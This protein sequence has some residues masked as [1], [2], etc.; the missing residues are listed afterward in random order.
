MGWATGSI[1]QRDAV[2]ARSPGHG[3]LADPPGAADGVF[4]LVVEDPCVTERAIAKPRG[5][6]GGCGIAMSVPFPM[7]G[8]VA[9]FAAR[10]I[11]IRLSCALAAVSALLAADPF[12]AI[13]DDEEQFRGSVRVAVDRGVSFLDKRQAANGEIGTYAWYQRDQVARTWSLWRRWYVGTPFT[14]SQVLHSLTFVEGGEVARR[15]RQ[16]AVAY[17][18]DQRE[19]PGVWRYY[20]KDRTPHPISPDVDDTAQAW[21][22]LAEQGIAVDRDALEALKRSRTTAGLFNTWIGNPEKWVGVDSRDMSVGVNLNAL[23]LFALVGQPVPEVCRHVI[24]Y[25]STGAFHQGSG[26]YPSPLAHTYFL[27]R[28]YADGH[29]ACLAEAI[30]VVRSY[31]L[32]QQQA[33]G[34]WGDDLRTALGLLTLLNVGELGPPVQ[35]GIRVLLARQR[36]DGGWALAPLYKGAASA[37]HYGSPS[38]TTGFCLEALGKYLRKRTAPGR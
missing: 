19:P 37:I 11:A 7:T 30:P 22:A 13:G 26:Y 3:P 21:A 2:A 16:R 36:P 27:T 20:A 31:V 33:D 23:F 5:P 34:G 10:R 12:K 17:L 14:A 6:S 24:A 38:L 35:Q 1:T 28:A 15:I 9:A 32:Q 29:A 8:V 18:L 4:G 25:T